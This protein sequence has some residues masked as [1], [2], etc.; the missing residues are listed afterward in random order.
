[1]VAQQGVAMKTGSAGGGVFGGLR[2]MMGGESFFINTFTGE[3]GGGQVCL[4]PGTPGDIGSF[5]LRPGENLF[6]QGSSFLACT[7]NVQTDSQFQGFGAS[8]A[9]E[10]RFFCGLTP[11]G[12]R[13]RSITTPTG[14]IK[15][16]PVE[17]GAG[18]GGGHRAPGGL[19]R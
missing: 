11:N 15:Q 18:T 6:I 10:S 4:A 7:E 2:R 12:G 1:M 9:G 14:R 3:H 13:G 5:E 16:L 8:S 17:P 19:Y